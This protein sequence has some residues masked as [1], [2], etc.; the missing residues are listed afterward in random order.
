MTLKAQEFGSR[1]T[2]TD[3]MLNEEANEQRFRQVQRMLLDANARHLVVTGTKATYA[4]EI[5][6]ERDASL[7]A[8][9]YHLYGE[10]IPELTLLALVAKQDVYQRNLTQTL[11]S[12]NRLSWWKF[13][14]LKL[15]G[16]DIVSYD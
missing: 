16:K 7:R 4:L 5:E 15:R 14:W 6:I 12:V 8:Y 10:A 1:L 9:D 2:I 13:L 3:K 11:F